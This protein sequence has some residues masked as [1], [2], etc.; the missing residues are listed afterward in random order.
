MKKKIILGIFFLFI[1]FSFFI[2]FYFKSSSEKDLIKKKEFIE[3]ENEE[4]CEIA[5]EN[6]V[7]NNFQRKINAIPRNKNN[8]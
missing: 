7:I 8:L 5:N 4:S 1:I 3:S 2:F 6:I